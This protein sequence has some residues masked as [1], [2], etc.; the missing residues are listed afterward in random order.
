MRFTDFIVTRGN[1]S[2]DWQARL[3]EKFTGVMIEKLG[4]E[5]AETVLK[6]REE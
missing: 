5:A 2:E 3:D 1:E 6:L 4:A